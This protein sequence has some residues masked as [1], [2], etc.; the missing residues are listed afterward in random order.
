MLSVLVL[1]PPTVVQSKISDKTNVNLV[2]SHPDDPYG[3]L[4]DYRV[5]YYGF[6]QAN[7]ANRV[8]LIPVVH[9]R[10]LCYSLN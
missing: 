1:G 3:I 4:L 8:R 5:I 6:K 7:A 2:W 10:C 9:H